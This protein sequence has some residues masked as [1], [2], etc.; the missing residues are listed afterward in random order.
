[1]SRTADIS[2]LIV[3]YRSRQTIKR[4]LDALAAQTV[5]PREIL[6]L[7]NGSPGGEDVRPADMSDCIRFEISGENLGFAAG[8]NLL[9]RQAS[10][11]WLALLNPDAYAHPDWIEKLEDATRRYPDIAMFGST[12]YCAESPDL[13]DGTGD[14]YH[15]AGLAYRSGYRRPS[16]TPP[17]EGEVFGPCAAAALVRRDVFE[18]LGG[19]EEGFFCYNEDVDLAYRARLAGYRAI[20]LAGAAVDHAGYASSGRRSELTTYYGVRNRE[21]VFFRNTPGWL[22]PVLLPV[23]LVATTALW[24]SAARFGQFVLYGTALRDAW[25][26]RGDLSKTRREVQT[27]VR[28]KPSEIASAMVWNPIRLFTRAA[29]VRPWPAQAVSTPEVRE[30]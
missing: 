28:V 13:F 9:A 17:P 23:H 8:N 19:F 1:M 27:S 7:E 30:P 10:G 24:L 18:K 29:G 4:C 3:A 20:Q 22:L 21:W 5:R 14:V 26:R 16:R 11:R 6:L 15:A 12:Q 25:T 2:V